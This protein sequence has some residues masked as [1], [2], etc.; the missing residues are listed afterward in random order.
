L[1]GSSPRP[2]PLSSLPFLRWVLGSL[3]SVGMDLAN[4]LHRR[5]FQAGHDAALLPAKPVPAAAADP[6][7]VTL[8]INDER[9]IAAASPQLDE[10][11]FTSWKL[12]IN[13]AI[14]ADFKRDLQNRGENPVSLTP[15]QLRASTTADIGVSLEGASLCGKSTVLAFRALVLHHY[16]GMREDSICLLT[17]DVEA[18]AVAIERLGHLLGLWGYPDASVRAARMVKTLPEAVV[19]VGRSVPGLGGVRLF[20]CGAGEESAHSPYASRLPTD[21]YERIEAFAAGLYKTNRV[22]AQAVVELYRESLI[23]QRLESDDP[24]VI[25][26]SRVGLDLEVYDEALTNQ[27][28]A[29]W[30]GARAWPIAGVTDEVKEIE[31]CGRIYRC[32]GFIEQLGAYV[33]LGFDRSEARHLRREPQARLEL[34]KEVEIKKTM[35]R[36]YGE[37]PIIHLDSYQQARDLIASL[38]GLGTKMPAIRVRSSAFPDQRP[39]AM[40]VWEVVSFIEHMGL[41]VRGAIS[42]CSYMPGDSESLMLKVVSLLWSSF[43]RHLVESEP[44]TMTYGRLLSIF[45]GANGGNLR[46]VPSDTLA[47]YRHL[48]VDDAQE[49]SPAAARWI[50]SILLEQKRRSVLKERTISAPGATLMFAGDPLGRTLGAKGATSQPLTGFG[51]FFG[52]HGSTPIQLLD[53]FKTDAHLVGLSEAIAAPMSHG[54]VRATVANRPVVDGLV[55]GALKLNAFEQNQFIAEVQAGIDAGQTVLVV[56]DTPDSYSKI[57]SL[58]LPLL[59]AEKR[60]G[61]R[62]LLYIR[63]ASKVREVQADKLILIGGFDGSR[64]ESFRNQVFQLAGQGSM[65]DVAPFATAMH[66]DGIASVA[67]CVARASQAVV[68]FGAGRRYLEMAWAKSITASRSTTEACLNP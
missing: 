51:A 15:T 55:S 45:A 59:D 18:K 43:E 65:N 46:F 33:V 63:Q 13:S 68:W 61:G 47:G 7:H 40:V 58:V 12:P 62:K 29:L 19:D 1:N 49:L 36:A 64:G 20:E 57:A 35:L 3:C 28:L 24:D 8:T 37:V 11:V 42:R 32:H 56:P 67:S 44:I 10:S 41:D 54:R 48:L 23:L 34:F 31:L 9:S 38:A 52:L 66:E 39:L 21:C 5:S 60:A 26:R 14:R 16:M 22:F 25:K 53:N 27:V 4:A 2:V 30:K 6:V 17:P 50:R